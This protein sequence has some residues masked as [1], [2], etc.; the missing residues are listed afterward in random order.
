MEKFPPLSIIIVTLNSQ[1]TLKE[2]LQ[3]IKEQ[4]Y[5]SL[6]E[7]LIIDGGSTDDTLDIAKESGLPIKVIEGGYR[8]NQEARRAVGILKAK[9][10]I[11]AF[12]DSDNY[13]LDK[14]WLKDMVSPLLEDKKII[15][16]QTLRYAAPK[17]VTVLNR[18]FGLLGA[19][20]PVAYYLGKA[21]RL[22][23]AFD[24][25][26]L[27]GKVIL[28]NNKYLVVEF[29]ENNYP[30]VGCNGIVFKRSILL[31]VASKDP[32][33][34]LHTDV[35]IDV[36][37]LGYN[38][39]AIV[40]NEIFH[41]TAGNL[42]SF[43]KKRRKYMQLFHQEL[44]KT[45]RHLIFNPRKLSEVFRLIVFIIF[46]ITIIEPFLESIR[47]YI[48]KRDIAWFIHPL[49]CLGLAIVY[50]EATIRHKIKI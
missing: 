21:D 5:P 4:S 11:C 40:K 47:G 49:L 35:F 1:R 12:I 14:N 6:S 15:A 39:F 3:Y 16:S 26:N 18:Y 10:E 33:N 46:S 23:W 2:C 24:E 43:L 7:V 9:N 42:W 36:G 50:A 44:N 25:W 38:K 29:S 17:N 8:D 32:K 48:K 31:K 45:R 28:Q 19:A 27:L 20:D 41:N 34:Y 13:I 22:S 30:T 37:K